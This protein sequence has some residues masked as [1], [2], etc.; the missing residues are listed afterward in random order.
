MIVDKDAFSSGQIASKI[1]LAKELEK[2]IEREGNPALDILCLGGWYGITNFILQTR[3]NLT[4]NKF[5]SIDID[6]AV[7]TVADTINNLWEWESWRFKAVTG[8][9]NQF[10]YCIDDFNLVINTSVEHIDSTAWFENIPKG[11]FIVLQSNDMKH[12]DHSHNHE[13]LDDMVDDFP[14]DQLLY[15]G[16]LEF[17]Y[18][19]W[20]FKRF[21]II[22]IK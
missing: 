21:M 9:A 17:N 5:R 15:K 8:D 2:I 16:E 1:W 10:Q 12:E 22:G 14:I 13:S 11:S 4:I 7:E 19:E 18:P 20:G 3:G 6:P